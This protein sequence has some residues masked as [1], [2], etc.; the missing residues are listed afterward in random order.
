MTT[1]YERAL[2]MASVA[3]VLVLAA[4]HCSTAFEGSGA[5]AARR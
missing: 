5:R 2:G 4:Q 1:S 3:T